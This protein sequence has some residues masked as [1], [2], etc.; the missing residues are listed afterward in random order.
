[1]DV[2]AGSGPLKMPLV[3]ELDGVRA[4]AVLI[5]FLSH[6]GFARFVPGGLGV[7]IFF[8]LSGYLITSL[9][10]AEAATT[11]RVNFAGFYLRRTLRIF[12]PLYIT[13][14]LAGLV[15]ATGLVTRDISAR[16]VW[17]QVL[18]FSNYDRLL[19]EFRGLPGPPL[20]SL[21]VE[22]HF[23][24]LFPL[25]FSLVLMRL[26]PRAAGLWCAIACLVPLAFRL[27]AWASGADWTLNYYLTH[28][29]VD[30]LLFGCSLAL[31]NNPVLQGERAWQPNLAW[32]AGAL[33]LLAAAT[34][35]RG[36][37]YG[38]TWR[39][40]LQGIALYGIFAFILRPNRLTSPIL[41]TPVMQL[42]GRYSYSLYLVHVLIF[43]VL[44]STT[45]MPWW[46]MAIVTAALSMV[47]GWAMFTL[48][49]R[50]LARVRHRLHREPAPEPMVPEPMMDVD[51]SVDSGPV[52][53]TVPG[54]T[55][56]TN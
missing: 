44:R 52:T 40:T 56:W 50:P 48:V 25:L 17:S 18:F 7:T 2:I 11:G 45:V 5:V 22:E 12:P 28:T 3:R 10:Y 54:R 37:V 27:L 43:V 31:W 26:T 33:A 32:F 8:F 1:M 35:A 51:D 41:N 38:E 14:A 30:S 6:V 46:L 23:Y 42:I 9:L 47:Y 24:L 53:G 13:L 21:A 20:W 15:V 19:G 34:L 39:Y 16:S 4:I 49:E 29:R 36:D 55:S